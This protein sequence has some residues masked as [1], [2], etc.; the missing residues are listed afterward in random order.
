MD[1]VSTSAGVVVAL[2]LYVII[3]IAHFIS[4]RTAIAH[5]RLRADEFG[6]FHIFKQNVF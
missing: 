3:D 6:D 5:H 4:K 2:M 1:F